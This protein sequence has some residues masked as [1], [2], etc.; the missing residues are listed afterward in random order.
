[1]NR[2]RATVENEL[3]RERA[4]LTSEK[5]R[6]ADLKGSLAEAEH[7]AA[8]YEAAVS[9]LEAFLAAEGAE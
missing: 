3:R 1:M 5:R 4:A 7:D 8:L 9:E 6:I 2:V